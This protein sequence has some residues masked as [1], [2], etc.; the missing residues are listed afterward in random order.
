M[1]ERSDGNPAAILSHSDLL[2]YK[3]VLQFGLVW[4]YGAID[5]SGLDSD[6]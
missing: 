4:L 5:R 1:L 3:I 2:Q 6:S